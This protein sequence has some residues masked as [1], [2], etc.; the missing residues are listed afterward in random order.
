MKL[1]LLPL[2]L[3]GA[4]AW[5]GFTAHASSSDAA[6][7]TSDSCDPENCHVTV[8]CTDHHTCIVTCTDAAGNVRCREEVPCDDACQKNCEKPCDTSKACDPARTCTR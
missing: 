2:L 1:L 8:E 4:G 7:A 6:P 5:Y 3:L